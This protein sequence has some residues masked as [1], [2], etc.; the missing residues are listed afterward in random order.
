MAKE[1]PAAAAKTGSRSKKTGSKSLSRLTKDERLELMKLLR[2]QNP[3]PKPELHY[4]NA[5]ELLCAVL[6]S[7][8][9]TDASVNKVTEKLFALAPDPEKMVEL[10]EDRIADC[11]KSIGLWKAK[12]KNL[13]NMSRILIESFN[14]KVPSDFDA[15]VSLPGVGGKTAY[16]VQNVFFRIPVIAVDTHIFR[17]CNRTGLCPGKNALEV[18][19][20]LPAVID[21][22]FKLDA[23]HYI[24]LHGR[25]ICT[26]RSPKCEECVIAHL[27]K[28]KKQKVK[29]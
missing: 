24:L 21:D 3:N 4:K 10:G 6:L 28:E 1:Q 18:Q 16:V 15:L 14:S 13:F 7:A 9:A 26:A 12:S 20:R 19:K 5:Y 25:Y 23:H 8:Q 27:C 11:I 29:S 17:V 2:R 22:T